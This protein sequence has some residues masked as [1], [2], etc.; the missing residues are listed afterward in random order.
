MIDRLTEI[1]KFRKLELKSVS[2]ADE[3]FNDGHTFTVTF[4]NGITW[5]FLTDRPDLFLLCF[6]ITLA[7]SA[8]PINFRNETP[9][10]KL[11]HIQ[12]KRL[13][14]ALRLPDTQL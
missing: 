4:S 2:L 3:V 8:T 7:T 12:H 14:S 10:E 13:L 9:R 6:E 1:A 11:Q 5:K